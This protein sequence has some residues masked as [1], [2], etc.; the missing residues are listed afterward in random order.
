MIEGSKLFELGRNSNS[1]ILAR[2]LYY[3]DNK[4]CTN[5]NFKKEREGEAVQVNATWM[6]S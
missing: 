4:I 1:E 2:Y 5:K 3:H 6:L